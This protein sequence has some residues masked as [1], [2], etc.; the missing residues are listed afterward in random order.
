VRH[1]ENKRTRSER[2]LDILVGTIAGNCSNAGAIHLRHRIGEAIVHYAIGSA[3][4]GKDK[5]EKV[6]SKAETEMVMFLFLART[7]R[8]VTGEAW[9]RRRGGCR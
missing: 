1:G 9:K 7:T 8:G 6:S 2:R 3:G 4:W 5:G